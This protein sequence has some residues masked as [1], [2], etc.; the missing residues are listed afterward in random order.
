MKIFVTLCLNPHAPLTFETSLADVHS[1][2]ARYGIS[3][4]T[5]LANDGRV[6]ASIEAGV[7]DFIHSPTSLLCITQQY[8]YLQVLL[9]HPEAVLIWC[10]DEK[11]GCRFGSRKR[12]KDR[13]QKI[14]SGG[15]NEVE[16]G[17]QIWASWSEL[18]VEGVR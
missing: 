16:T 15:R 10:A 14:G 3:E 18:D 5:L 11:A 17:Y 12:R 9:K 1:N 2:I 13:C 8:E 4:G 7:V 6:A